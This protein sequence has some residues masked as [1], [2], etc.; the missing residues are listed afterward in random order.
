[1]RHDLDTVDPGG[2]GLGLHVRN[3][4]PS[5]ATSLRFVGDEQQ[6]ELR[7]SEDERV[8]PEDSASMIVCADGYEG[9]VGFDVIRTDPVARHCGCVL[10]LVGARATHE[11]RE[12]FGIPR[13]GPPY[14]DRLADRGS[15]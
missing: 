7:W 10:T 6:V 9:A 8:E 2:T 1:M 4:P 3:K 5:N 11:P 14:R 13:D 15:A 12:P